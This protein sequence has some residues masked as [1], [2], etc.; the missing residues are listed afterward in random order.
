MKNDAFTRRVVFPTEAPIRIMRL[1]PT[2][3]EPPWPYQ[4]S[5]VLR[6]PPRPLT[7]AEFRRRVR[8]FSRIGLVMIGTR[9]A[10]YAWDHL[11]LLD[12]STLGG[13]GNMVT[14]AYTE[15]LVALACIVAPDDP[16]RP[17]PTEIDF[18]LLCWELHT[19]PDAGWLGPKAVD[20]LADALRTFPPDHPLH[21]LTADAV[22]GLLAVTLKARLAYQQGVGRKWDGG[23]LLR[24]W[25]V[26]KEFGA[27]ARQAAGSRYE[28][29]E[30]R[31]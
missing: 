14:Q 21:N 30:R 17:W 22:R 3:N 15:R 26:T 23:D 6:P 29:F 11:E 31:F 28:E 9:L 10:W 2:P 4:A 12:P 19:C 16:N 18:R 1:A 8:K 13:V 27:L 5:R 20:A 7:F 25:L 24:P